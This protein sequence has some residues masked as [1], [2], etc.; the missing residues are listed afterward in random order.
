[1]INQP[2][3]ILGKPRQR[4][5]LAGEGVS[6]TQAEYEL[7]VAG[8]EVQRPLASVVIGGLVSSTLLT[9]FLLPVQDARQTKRHYGDRSARSRNDRA[10]A[11]DL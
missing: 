10:A 1:M 9:L 6:G 3:D 7:M 11:R 4:M 2:L 8:A 5:A